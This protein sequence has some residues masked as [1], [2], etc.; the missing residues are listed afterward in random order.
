[1]VQMDSKAINKLIRSEVWPILREQGFSVFDARSAVAY[2]GPFINV[3]SF[4]SFNSYLAG[5]LGCT[6]FSFTPRLGVYVVGSPRQHRV[7]RDKDGRLRP[8]EYECALRSELRKR[9]PV[10]G[11][12]RD[13]VFYIDPDGRTTAQCFQELKYLCTEVAPRWFR[14]NNDLEY[15]LSRM[16]SAEE[17][18]SA[19]FLDATGRP[20]SYNWDVLRSVLLLAKHQQIPNAQSA[21]ASLDSIER[22]IGNILDFSTI[23]SG[24]RGE[25]QY[26]IEIQ[27]LW[28]ELGEHRPA[29][30]RSEALATAHGCLDDPAWTN[31]SEVFIAIGTRGTSDEVSARK[32]LWPALRALGFSEFTDRLAHRASANLVETV[33]FLPV[34]QAERNA[35]NLPDHLFRIGVGIHWPALAEDGLLRKN[36]GGEP[37]PTVNE[38]HIS[39]WL[40]PEGVACSEARTAFVSME[41]ATAALLGPGLAWLNLLRNCESALAL[42]QRRDWELFWS[43]PMMR[44]YGA[45]SSSR[46]FVYT[47]HLNLLLG[48]ESEYRDHIRRAED[49]FRSWYP[50]HLHPRYEAWMDQVKTRLAK[51]EGKPIADPKS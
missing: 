5:G 44:G 39:N 12:A 31:R 40:V 36:K 23:Q 6:T 43:Y 16:R 46:R 51:L 26:A 15:L 50:E 27:E 14:R 19:P 11:F 48:K 25:E 21:S 28:E 13:D 7:K 1:M 42:L 24:R 34:D 18:N 30:A 37:R 45:S 8:F 4:Q 29:P 22:A 38:C 33:E 41:V 9:T 35:W 20:G 49:S 2:I 10:D 32:Q 3:V 47:A 17:P